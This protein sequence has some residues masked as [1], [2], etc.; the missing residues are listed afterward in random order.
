MLFS[1][2][3]FIG[4]NPAAPGRPLNY[5]ALDTDLRLVAMDQADFET[6]LAF[7][8]G[9]EKAVVAINAPQGRGKGFMQQPEVRR[10][11]NL[12]PNGKTWSKWRVCEYELRR[13]NIRV[14]NSPS[15][16]RLAPGWV[17]VGLQVYRRLAR[18][19]FALLVVEEEPRG[20]SVLEVQPHAGYSVLLERQPFTKATLEGR[21]QR[22]LVLYLQG[23]DIV[24][25]M[26]AL[27]EVTRHHLLTGR[28]PLEGLLAQSDLDALLAAFTAYLA[29]S[30][31][32]RVCQLGEREEGFLTVPAPELLDFY[33]L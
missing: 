26:H 24:N 21:L 10:R 3:L 30:Q 8:A 2:A 23:I 17:D 27:E 22:Q 9:Q 12:D 5:A 4:L 13:R 1:D 29:A 15:L 7:I 33:P 32:E 28:L 20:R 25:P 11:Y 18:L 16:E 6:A 31:P 19:G 14:V